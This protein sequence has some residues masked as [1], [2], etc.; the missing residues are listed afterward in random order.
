M[1]II[2]III[3]SFSFSWPKGTADSEYIRAVS[4]KYRRCPSSYSTRSAVARAGFQVK[5]RPKTA[6]E[7]V[8]PSVR[9]RTA[10]GLREKTQL[11]EELMFFYGRN[12]HQS[13]R[14]VLLLFCSLLL[15][16]LLLFAV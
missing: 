3:I 10:Q 8:P 6:V 13:V 1:Y 7:V 11:L 15:F 14:G 5:P 2:I 12:V 16:Y 9:P 4:V